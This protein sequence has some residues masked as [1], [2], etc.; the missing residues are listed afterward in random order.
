M[1]IN[2]TKI[3]IA[4]IEAI[5]THALT[6][7]HF[8]GLYFQISLKTRSTE[9]I[10]SSAGKVINIESTKKLIDLKHSQCYQ[11]E[12]EMAEGNPGKQKKV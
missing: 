5:V 2:Q 6:L 4:H 10:L 1:Q 8:L 3:E 11:S 12:F 9:G 7:P